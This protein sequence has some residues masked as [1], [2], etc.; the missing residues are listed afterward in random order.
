M[1]FI[2]DMVHDNPGEERFKTEFR[3]PEKLIEYGYNTQVFKH[4]NTIAEFEFYDEDFFPTQESRQWMNKM[5]DI[6][7]KEVFDAKKSGLMV[8]SHIDLFVLPKLLFDRFKNEICDQNGKISIFKERTKEIH[9]VMFDEIFEKY[10]VDGLIVRVGET[11]LFDT[12]YHIGNGAVIYGDIESEKQAFI[13]LIN[14]LKEEVCDKHG[15]YLVFRTW[16]LFSDKFHANE[17]YYLDITDKINP[18]DKLL[19]SIKHTALDFWRNVK[20]N[21]CLGAG[22]HKQVVEVQCQRE[23]EGKGAYP[24][25]VMNGVINGFSENKIKKGLKDI[26]DNPLISGIYAW[27]RGGGWNG[28]YIKNE[29][30]CDINSYVIGQYGSNPEQSEED[31]FFRYAKEKMGLDFENSKKFYELCLKVP[32]AVLFGRYINQYDAIL[33]EGIMPSANWLRD[34]DIGGLRQLSE[35]FKYLEK[36]NLVGE[37]IA[38]KELS[39]KLWYEI[40]DL[41]SKI[42]VPNEELQ[43]FIAN[44]IE[45]GLRFFKVIELCFKIMAKCRKHENVR[46]LIEEYDDAWRKYKELELKNQA[47]SSYNLDYKFDKDGH[48]FDEDLKYC[49]ANLC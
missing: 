28:P 44:S 36:N 19:F 21:P 39:V 5:T 24:M 25:Y 38:D 27:S 46:E 31:I 8:M 10:P 42:Q 12:P 15:K 35:V 18:S 2:M 6:V 14:F 22:K 43:E 41:F 49:R 26:A 16:D 45:Y 17:Q 34:D 40:K 4:L 3:K 29:F 47:S 1:K 48:G 37:S 32:N 7:K 30:W 20:F 11:Y 23:Y 9:R 13:E 33:N